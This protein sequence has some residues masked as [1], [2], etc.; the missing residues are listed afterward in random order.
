MN[1]FNVEMKINETILAL[2]DQGLS[3]R[4]IAESVNLSKSAVHRRVVK[5]REEPDLN[6]EKAELQQ[7]TTRIRALERKRNL[8]ETIGDRIVQSAKALPAIDAYDPPKERKNGYLKEEDWVHV[9]SDVQAGT[10]FNKRDAG[11]LNEFNTER[12]KE[13]I[14]FYKESFRDILDYH[15]NKPKVGRVFLIGD[16]IEGTTIFHG[17][18]R[19]VDMNTIEQVMF[20]VDE[21]S[22]L[23]NYLSSFYEK[24]KVYCIVGNHGRIG[25]KGENA[26]LDNFDY[27][28]YQWMKERL[29]N[30]ER[31]SFNI[32]ESWFQIVNVQGHNFCLIHGDNT[33]H[34]ALGISFY[35]IQRAYQ[36]LQKML[37]P[38][39]VEFEYLVLGHHHNPAEF[40]HTFVNG[41]WP[42][43]S[44]LSINKMMQQDEPQQK[45]FAVNKPFGVSWK[46]DILLRDPRKRERVVVYK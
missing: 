41:S 27:L 40:Y 33:P 46:R 34:G 4:E 16:M 17:Q 29:R 23:L 43:G 37:Q 14:N 32:P 10:S 1:T 39:G 26:V 15:V 45:L 3:V 19:A 18:Q 36:R 21:F 38:Y 7:L 31:I 8:W 35:G 20:V 11:G 13:Y 22:H 5:L 25:K 12:L 2:R 42:G 28:A 9:I 44:E 24:L 6:A 30:N